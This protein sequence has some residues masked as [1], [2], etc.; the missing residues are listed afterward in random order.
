M[1]DHSIYSFSASNRWIPCPA[2]IRL[3]KG[4]KSE[5][6]AAAELG[7]AAHELGEFSIKY[8]ANPDECVGMTFNKHLVDTVMAD[9]IKIYVGFSN[10]LAVKSGVK[11]L[12]EQK[13]IMSSLGRS[14]AYGT[15]DHF[16][17][18]LA[19][20]TLYVSDLKYGYGIVE[21]TGNTQLKAYSI[22]ALDTWK[23]WPHID[24]VVTTIIQPRKDH[25]DGFIRQHIYST[26][27]LVEEQK[28]FAK[29][30]QLAEDPNTQPVA[31]AHCKYCPRKDCRTRLIY[32]LEVMFPD[33]PLEVMSPGEVGLIYN[34]I[35]GVTRFLKNIEMLALDNARKSLS[36]PEGHK[37]VNAIQR[38][39]IIDESML[40]SDCVQ[41]GIDESDLYER[42]LKSKTNLKKIVPPELVNKHYVA[43]PVKTTLAPL[44]NNRPSVSSAR[45]AAGI[46]KAI[47]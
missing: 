27:E 37:L 4:I 26:A 25:I 5:T 39:T 11:P 36:I 42:K 9:F 28:V 45:S 17:V 2:S 44:S 40:V 24:R 33:S 3:S 1:A 41:V 34:R 46:F 23:L 21:V 22:S 32:E 47:K 14:D 29:A 12:L 35:G 15:G 31:G 18:D 43:P 13:V 10:S 30:I 19:N 8:G 7:T 38:H 16:L 6:S 20:R